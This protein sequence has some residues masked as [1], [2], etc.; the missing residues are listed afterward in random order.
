M[1][2]IRPISESTVR[3]SQNL[4]IDPMESQSDSPERLCA[5]N[6]TGQR[7][8]SNEVLVPDSAGKLGDL[9]SSLSPGSAAA[10]WIVPIQP[11][12]ASSFRFPVDLLFL[13][14]SGAVVEA[15]QSF[16]LAR[17]SPLVNK[18]ASILVLPARGVVSEGIAAGDEVMV[19]SPKEMQHHLLKKPSRSTVKP[20]LVSQHV[21]VVELVQPDRVPPIN[22]SH[23]SH[24]LGREK[25]IEKSASSENIAAN[26]VAGPS[27]VEEVEIAGAPVPAPKVQKP[28]PKSWWQKLLHEEPPDPRKAERT[29]L[30]G[31]IAYFF[32]GGVPKGHPVRDI[33]KTGLFVLTNERWYRGTIV[34]LT[35]TDEREPTAERTITL[36]AKTVRSTDDGVA[37]HF[38]LHEKTDRLRGTVSTLDNLSGGCSITQV[39]AFIENYRSSL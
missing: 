13:D 30:P 1:A 18:A 21:A 16:P 12:A 23:D 22:S 36:H 7:F 17:I 34:R 27:S 14:R 20:Q 9:L 35:L 6:L 8:I 25:P 15:V 5:Y 19:C 31:L 33:S 10:V 32:T 38:V 3:Q 37:L 28:A 26:P 2:K 29:A 11:L 39:E 24:L 4:D